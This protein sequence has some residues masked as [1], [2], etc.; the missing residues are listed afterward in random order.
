MPGFAR[1]KARVTALIDCSLY[2]VGEN[3]IGRHPGD[4]AVCLVM[5]CGNESGDGFP[6]PA[7][8]PCGWT[9]LK[10]SVCDVVIKV[11]GNSW[12][13][14]AAWGRLATAPRQLCRVCG[15]GPGLGPRVRSEPTCVKAGSSDLWNGFVMRPWVG[16][17]D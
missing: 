3:W 5:S 10:T 16:G 13:M 7:R 14:T 6:W 2:V 8:V 1:V 12:A 17:Y 4:R 11:D 9:F 15:A